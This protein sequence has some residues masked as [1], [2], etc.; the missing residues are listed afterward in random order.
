MRIGIMKWIICVLAYFTPILFYLFIFLL[1]K[2]FLFGV[3]DY[4]TSASVYY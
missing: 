2:I 4:A 1:K 3:T